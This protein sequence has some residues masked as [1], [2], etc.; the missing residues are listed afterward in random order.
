MIWYDIFCHPHPASLNAL[1]LRH[2]PRMAAMLREDFGKRLENILAVPAHLI[3]YQGW[4]PGSLP[5]SVETRFA[6]ES[7]WENWGNFYDFTMKNRDFSHLY[8]FD[9]FKRWPN[10]WVTVFSFS[11]S[12]VVEVN[13][14]PQI[15]MLCVGHHILLVLLVYKYYIYNYISHVL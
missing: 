13:I 10:M 12:G 8:V 5:R 6:P 1:Q 7:D 4:K 14:I 3:H 11:F 9:C 15:C 2:T